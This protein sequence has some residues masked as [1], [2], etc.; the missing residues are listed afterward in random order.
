MQLFVKRIAKRETYTIGQLFING[1]YFCDTLE[2]TDRGLNAALPLEDNKRKKEYG[3]T[4]I[5]TGT[6]RVDLHTVS[7]KFR[8]RSWA[9]PYGGRLPRLLNV[10]AFEGVLIHVGNDPG[11]TLGCIL[12]GQNKEKGRVI[13]STAT[14]NKLMAVL[15][16]AAESDES[17]YIQIG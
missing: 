10:P 2:D 12:V 4:A 3:T 11:D 14:F 5:P 17:V 7:E 13:N 1:E 6:Y 8:D 9:R 15:Q 16:P